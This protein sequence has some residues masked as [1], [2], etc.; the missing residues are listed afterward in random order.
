MMRRRYPLVVPTGFSRSLQA[1]CTPPVQQKNI[2]TDQ[3]GTRACHSPGVNS[4]LRP[5]SHFMHYSM[6]LSVCQ[7]KVK[8]RIP[9]SWQDYLVSVPAGGR[10]NAAG[11]HL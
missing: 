6:L 5:I 9:V 3:Q 8:G 1:R 7:H 2:V 4:P 10:R 11:R